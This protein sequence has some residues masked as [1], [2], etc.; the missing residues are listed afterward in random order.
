MAYRLISFDICPFVQRA[1]IMLRAKGVDYDLE[2]I[3]LRDKPQWFLELSPL[4]KVPLLEV[5]G[6]T[7]LFESQVIAE[8]LDETNAPSMHPD[9]PLARA[10]DRALIELVS[11]A[12]GWT[13]GASTTADEDDAREKMGKVRGVLERLVTTRD[14]AGPFF[15]GD[16]LSIVDAAAA[17]LLQRANWADEIGGFGLFDA[18]PDA[19]AWL[20]ALQ[21]HP[22][23]RASTVDDIRDRVR[24]SFGGWLATRRDAA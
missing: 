3:D 18:V 11:N 17:P 14:D 1:A 19:R 24:R 6:E 5:D 16:T 7:I 10:K 22:A 21:E 13:Y 12:L 9:Q 15:H 20:S 4:G 23:V 2:Y 8:Y